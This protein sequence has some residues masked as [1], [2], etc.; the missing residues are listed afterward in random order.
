MSSFLICFVSQN[1][2]LLSPAGSKLLRKKADGS[3]G[4]ISSQDREDG[5]EILY[6]L[7]CLCSEVRIITCFFFFSCCAQTVHWVFACLHHGIRFYNPLL[8]SIRVIV[9]DG[10]SEQMSASAIHWPPDIYFNFIV[11]AYHA[12]VT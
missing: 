6:L 11:G 12:L 3:T 2:S 5:S 10:R 7:S 1:S 9:L 4:G 8:A